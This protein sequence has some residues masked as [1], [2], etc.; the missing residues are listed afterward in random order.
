[1][2]KNE[3]FEKCLAKVPQNIRET[4]SSRIDRNFGLAKCCGNCVHCYETRADDWR[5]TGKYVL[6]CEIDKEVISEANICDSFNFSENL[7][8]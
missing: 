6:R 5:Q 7:D 1:M 8:I 3:L 4:V 2:L